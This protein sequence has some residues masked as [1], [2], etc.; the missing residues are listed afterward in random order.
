MADIGHE[1]PTHLF[2]RFQ[3]RDV[4]E[5]HQNRGT[6]LGSDM[7]AVYLVGDLL[8]A[9]CGHIARQARLGG[10]PTAFNRIQHRWLAQDRQ[11]M[12]SGKFIRFQQGHGGT[13]T[14]DNTVPFCNQKGG[15]RDRRQSVRDQHVRHWS[16]LFPAL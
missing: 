9:C 6:V 4:I 1:I 13:V 11:Q 12:P 10:I 8:P 3:M 16:Y 7:A 14:T 5:G 2:R 15:H